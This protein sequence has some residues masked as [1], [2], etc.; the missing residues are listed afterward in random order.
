MK[1]I[2]LELIQ[3]LAAKCRQLQGGIQPLIDK[4]R[5][6]I[7]EFEKKHNYNSCKQSPAYWR[8]V[9]HVDALIRM[10]LFTEQNFNY[11]ESIGLLAL[12]RYLFELM[13]WLKLILKD[14]RYG[15]I[16]Y[17][18]LLLKQLNYFKDYRQH[19]SCE[20][21]FFKEIAAKESQLLQ[22][23]LAEAQALPDS[24]LRIRAFTR[25]GVMSGEKLMLQQRVNFQFMVNKH[26][27]MDTIIK[28]IL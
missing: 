3:E 15:L 22:T 18:E 21:S 13:I 20:I 2:T 7:A 25:L 27:L 14:N 11:L 24:D 4:F 12:T 19:L 16:Y 6:V 17:D 28:R 8:H 10:R 26:R 9:A 1:D 23:R 5:V